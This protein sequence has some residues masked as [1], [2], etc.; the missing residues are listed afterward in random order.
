MSLSLSRAL[1]RRIR[2]IIES[3]G[4]IGQRQPLGELCK[5]PSR[6]TSRQMA[7]ALQVLRQNA[8]E[9]DRLQV[10]QESQKKRSE[11]DRRALM[12]KNGGRFRAK[13]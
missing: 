3:Y 2:N 12:M 8:L 10:E 13:R 4:P 1:G 9:M 11:T 6:P 5:A 7:R